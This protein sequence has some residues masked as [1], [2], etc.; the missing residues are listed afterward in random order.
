MHLH[1]IFSGDTEMISLASEL[2]KKGH[3][4]SCEQEDFVNQLEGA[5][6]SLLPENTDFVIVGKCISDTEP[7]LVKA[8]N[9]GIKTGFCADFIY[10][11]FKNKTRVVIIGADGK[12]DIVNQVL[13][14]F[15]FQD[16]PLSYWVESSGSQAANFNLEAEFILIEGS[17]NPVSD[18]DMR[19]T[20]LCYK[21]NIALIEGISENDIK[22]NNYDSFITS[23]TAGGI[24]IYEEE[25]LLLKKIVE[26]NENTIRKIG[27]KTPDYEKN[28]N[29]LFI[30]TEEGMIPLKAVNESQVSR[31]E[32]AR[33][34]CQNMGIDETDFFQ[35]MINFS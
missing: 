30:I 10:E 22:S 25:N 8:R 35:A 24:I 13:Q 5:F 12:S 2:L 27:Y 20:F 14:T 17:E 19:P 28:G 31:V 34:L 1:F 3:S 23:I 7:I 4:V 11:Y 6:Y 33:W 9:Q 32:G 15:E 16:I 21:P 26:E 29:E 18:F